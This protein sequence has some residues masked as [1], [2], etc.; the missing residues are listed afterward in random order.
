[1]DGGTPAAP[2]TTRDEFVDT[3]RAA[4]ILRVVAVHVLNPLGWLW[5]P[6]PY[7]VMPGMPLV[8]F[9]SGALMLTSLERRPDAPWTVV[10]GR[11][12]RLLVPCVA[13]LAAMVALSAVLAATTG[14]ARYQLDFSGW[15]R[16]LVWDVPA[17]SAAV[18]AHDGQMWFVS[19][20]TILLAVS[21]VLARLH[22]RHLAL[23]ASL[24]LAAVVAFAVPDPGQALNHLGMYAPFFCVGFYYG[25]GTLVRAR[26]RFGA[27]PFVVGTG[28]FAAMSVVVLLRDGRNPNAAITSALTVATAWLLLLLAA[29]PAVQA[30]GRRWNRGVRWVSGRTLSIYLAGWP[31]T[32]AALRTADALYGADQRGSARWTATFLALTMVLVALGTV[33]IHPLENLARR[34]VDQWFRPRT[35]AAPPSAEPEQW[36]G[37]GSNP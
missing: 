10:R 23:P 19:T 37:R 11:L 26:E 6:A 21:P 36:A 3:V 20:F 27:L 22:R 31:A 16:W 8:F 13:V 32:R 24:V 29:R 15:Y 1:M 17:P 2:S 4:A 7:W 12:R 14:R 18:R 28:L 30:L 5:W 9:C 35:D 33:L 34:P 25:D